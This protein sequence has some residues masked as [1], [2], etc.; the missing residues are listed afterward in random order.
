MHRSLPG[1]LALIGLTL[2]ARPA[3]AQSTSVTLGGGLTIPTGEYGDYAKT[4]WLTALGVTRSVGGKG[5]WVGG[6]LVY[7][8]NS[9]SDVVG[10]KTNLPGVLGNLGY[11]FG[12]DK[13]AGPYLFAAA[14]IMNHQYKSNQYASESEWAFAYGLGAG[15]DI[16]AGKMALW[17]EAR[18][19]SRDGTNLIPLMVGV[20]IPVGK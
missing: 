8:S 19:L 6:E 9:H 2:A 13:K 14:G 12:D 11:R 18:Y 15:V 1:L 17:V 20:S 16:P 4:G 7:G 3:V 5:M 10:D